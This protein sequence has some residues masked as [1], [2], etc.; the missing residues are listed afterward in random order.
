VVAVVVTYNRRD[1]LIEALTAVL[2]QT[3]APDAVIVV[4]ASTD[5]T[6]EM[7][8]ARFP[9]V[10]LATVGATPAAPMGS[11]TAWRWPW[12]TRPTWS[13]WMDDDTVPEPGA[14]QAML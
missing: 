4:N 8:R 2:G 14:L 10:R 3:R 9:A 11:P 1:L 13:G 12:P 5:D 6:A 7:V